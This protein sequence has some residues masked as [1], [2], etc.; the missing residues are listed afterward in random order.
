MLHKTVSMTSCDAP[1]FCR[2]SRIE[3]SMAAKVSYRFGW[4]SYNVI[5][6]DFLLRADQ[7]RLKAVRWICWLAAFLHSFCIRTHL[8]KVLLFGKE[9]PVKNFDLFRTT[10]IGCFGLEIL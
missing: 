5:H 3:R 8:D 6:D 9:S 7:R 1:L 10:D 2:T 4:K